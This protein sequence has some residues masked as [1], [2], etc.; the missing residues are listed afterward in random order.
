MK[1]ILF[2]L[3]SA[4]LFS[5]ASHAQQI[6]KITRKC[7]SP[8]QNTFGNILVTINGDI[9]YTPCSGRS[10]IFT[11][12]VDFSGATI[13]GGGNVSATGAV[14][15]NFAPI[16]NTGAA[17]N[18]VNSPFS[19]DGTKYKWTASVGVD[20]NFRAELTPDALAGKWSVGDFSNSNQFGIFADETAGTPVVAI[21]ANNVNGQIQLLSN[22]LSNSLTVADTATFQGQTQTRIGNSANRILITTATDALT[23]TLGTWDLSDASG[24]GFGVST[25]K[26]LRTVTPSGTTGNQTINKPVGSV[27]FAAGASNITITNSTVTT[28]S[29]IFIMPQKADATCSVFQVDQV[30]AGSFHI[31]SPLGNC[32]AE[33]P[34]AFFVTN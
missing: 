31:N 19:W 2:I 6:D 10:S 3:L 30:A 9:T 27:N 23:T 33:T 14:T 32:T 34:V 12:T 18:L 24:A 15:T 20:S 5:C 7:P 1:K 21:N 17:K 22:G 11:G 26:Y 16:W 29:L 13:I 8:N 4:F 25:L 28:T